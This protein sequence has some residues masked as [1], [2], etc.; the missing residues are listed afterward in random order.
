MP[1]VVPRKWPNQND[2][3]SGEIDPGWGIDASPPREAVAHFRPAIAQD[4]P[5]SACSRVR[6]LRGQ[7]VTTCA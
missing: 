4:A 5:R 3:R 2:V 1:S 7:Q 6:Q